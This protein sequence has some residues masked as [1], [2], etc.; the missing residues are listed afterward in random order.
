MYAWLDLPE[1]KPVADA[2]R[3]YLQDELKKKADATEKQLENI[4]QQMF[5]NAVNPPTFPNL[6]KG[7]GNFDYF[8]GGYLSDTEFPADNSDAKSKV[9]DHI[10]AKNPHLYTA[11]ILRKTVEEGRRAEPASLRLRS[12]PAAHAEIE[13]I[14]AHNQKIDV[15][16]QF[17]K[18]GIYDKPLR[19]RDFFPRREDITFNMNE[20]GYADQ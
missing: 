17:I 3:A 15:F 2:L 11:F 10:Q 6:I 14:A 4:G 1:N 19:R 8:G 20:M 5:Q 9:R 16:L 18:S 12:D 13:K 7:L